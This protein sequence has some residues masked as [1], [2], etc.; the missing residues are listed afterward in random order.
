MCVGQERL[1]TLRAPLDGSPQLARRPY[2]RGFLRVDEYLRAETTADIGRYDPKPGFRRYLHES[3][4]HE[5]LEVRVLGS[6]VERID[7]GC[8]IVV[9]DGGAGFHGVGDQAV[10]DDV[11]RCDV[12]G[13]GEGRVGGGAVSEFPVVALVVGDRFVNLVRLVRGGHIYHRRQFIEIRDHRLRTIARRLQRIGDDDAVGF[14]DVVH[15]VHR[16]RRMGR[17]D[18]VRAI[19]RL[20]Q[21]AARQVADAVRRKIRPG[22]HGR[23]AGNLQGGGRV[24][25]GYGRAR[26]RR[27][28][29]Y[30]VRLARLVDVVRIATGAGNET[31]IFLAPDGGADACLCVSHARLL[32]CSPATCCRAQRAP[33]GRC[34]DIPCNGKG[35]LPARRAPPVRRDSRWSERGRWQP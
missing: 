17:L 15:A 27:A 24:Y 21:P 33:R 31:R 18:H 9:A 1:G 22:I 32:P 8:R 26:M 19:F 5:A 16:E 35:C 14:A 10:V 2:H 7:A 23:N 34:C 25:A 11:Q 3:G 29:E 4:Q 20:H 13:C 12:V 28:E 6:C 30:R